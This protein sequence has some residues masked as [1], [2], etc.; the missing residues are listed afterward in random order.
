MDS[1]FYTI[2]FYTIKFIFE[3]KLVKCLTYCEEI[4]RS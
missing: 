2:K 3:L 1:K 4:F